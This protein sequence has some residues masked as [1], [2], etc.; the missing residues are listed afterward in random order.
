MSKKSKLKQTNKKPLSNLLRLQSRC[1]TEWN[2]IQLWSIS[3]YQRFDY[4]EGQRMLLTNTVIFNLLFVFIHRILTSDGTQLY[5]NSKCPARPCLARAYT[6]TILVH[7]VTAVLKCRQQDGNGN[8][9]LESLRSKANKQT[10]QKS[11]SSTPCLP[12]FYL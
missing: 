3:E 7:M 10:N 12:C 11:L 9:D 1:S 6:T 2:K 5:C 8:K 4:H